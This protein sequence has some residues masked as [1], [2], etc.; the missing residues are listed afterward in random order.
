ME[1]T[2]PPGRGESLGRLAVVAAGLAACLLHLRIL[3]PDHDNAYLLD[4]AG[5]ML[6]GG[7]YFRDFMELN[8]PL[9]S[10]L[11]F[12]AHA[13]S[14]TGLPL[15]SAFI[16]WISILI[17]AAAVAIFGA[18]AA[19]IEDGPAVRA[20]IAIGV[21]AALFVVPAID[22]GQRDHVALVL[23]LPALI[24][25]AG[26]RRGAPV[27]AAG[28]GM[29]MA[30][31]LG[32]LI[33][34]YLVLAVAGAYA[35]RLAEERD[36]RLLIEPP[37]WC[38]AF[39]ACLYAGVI[40]VVFPEWFEVARIAQS[41]YSAYD[42]SE[43][44]SRRAVVAAVAIA[45]LAA[46][47]EMF[48]RQGERRLGRVLAA[49][50]AGALGSYVLQHKGIEYHFIP[51]RTLVWLLIGLVVL[52]G[53]RWAAALPLPAMLRR[54]LAM[55]SR[56]RVLVLCLVAVLPFYRLVDR[57]ALDE[58]GVDKSMRAMAAVL[59]ANRIGPRIAV[60]GTSVYPAYPLSLYRETLP[61]WRFAQPWMI[62]WILQQGRA[63]R[64]DA[65]DTVKMS[66]EMR[67]LVIEDFERYRP[68]AVLVDETPEKLFLP[69]DFD[70]MAWFRQDPRM[71]AI[72]DKYE[73]VAVFDDPNERVHFR[74]LAVYRR[75]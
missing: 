9:Y 48:G 15:Y 35:V 12:P 41:A 36:W 13:L 23:F 66:S 27:T 45:A 11:L 20:A 47:N 62:P 72:L 26:R 55:A 31:A 67:R 60:F 33:K 16:V 34:P 21:L 56:Y 49:A 39:I 6:A 18:L 24:W 65:P 43:W 70:I 5:R 17:T 28:C 46:A 7:R 57:T 38:F 44:I 69:K 64:A 8:P 3:A 54:W 25:Q 51:T 40:L 74:R 52:E 42:A 1:E 68:D 58:R 73:R 2:A 10:I 50:A 4:V 61:A 29:V 71:A 63:G 32:V 37:V 19:L 14:A 30:A 75:I 53:V 22:F 59:D